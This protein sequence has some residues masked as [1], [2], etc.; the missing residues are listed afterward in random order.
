MHVHKAMHPIHTLATPHWMKTIPRG[1]EV[2]R[3]GREVHFSKGDFAI[4][5]VFFLE[6][7]G[8][9]AKGRELTRNKGE[10]Q[11]GTKTFPPITTIRELKNKAGWSSW[12]AYGPKNRRK[13]S[14]TTQKEREQHLKADFL[15]RPY[16]LPSTCHLAPA[17]SLPSNPISC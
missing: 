8:V 14:K 5:S 10:L 7:R 16:G 2:D 3:K 4:F 17:A 11:E 6:K 1:R 12:T 9:E 15:P 13:R